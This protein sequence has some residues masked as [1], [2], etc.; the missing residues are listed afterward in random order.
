M[1]VIA[2]FTNEVNNL[3]LSIDREIRASTGLSFPP[4]Y[5]RQQIMNMLSST[6]KGSTLHCSAS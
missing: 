3:V 6:V 2:C 4:R 1:L 5:S